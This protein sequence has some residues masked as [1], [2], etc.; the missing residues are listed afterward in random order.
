MEFREIT[1]DVE[2]GVATITLNR[3]ER[4]NAFT[5]VM[6]GTGPAPSNTLETTTACGRS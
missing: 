2:D 5:P 4:L 3:P 6:L 1:Y